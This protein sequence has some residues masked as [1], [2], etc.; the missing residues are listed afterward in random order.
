LCDPQIYTY[1][2]L[3][4]SIE[5]ARWRNRVTEVV[6]VEQSEEDGRRERS[7]KA[8]SDREDDRVHRLRV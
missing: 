4:K 8:A 6:K 1:I 7:E 3:S 2:I 5:A